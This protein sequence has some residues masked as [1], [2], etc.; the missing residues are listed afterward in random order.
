MWNTISTGL[1]AVH[2]LALGLQVPVTVTWA[3]LWKELSLSHP[4]PPMKLLVP[5]GNLVWSQILTTVIV[6]AEE[7]K[8]KERRKK[9]KGAIVTVWWVWLIKGIKCKHTFF[10]VSLQETVFSALRN[11]LDY[12]KDVR[13]SA[14]ASPIITLFCC[15]SVELR[16]LKNITIW[17][18]PTNGE[19]WTAYQLNR[20][21]CY[22]IH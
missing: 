2:G 17:A 21:S 3:C 1:S 13:T 11:C 7:R 15:C 9:K 19:L 5:L 20:N 14:S 4:L 10:C 18:E 22:L 16:K 6:T 8:E 12:G